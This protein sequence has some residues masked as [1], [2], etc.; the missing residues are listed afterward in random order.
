MTVSVEWDIGKYYE[1]DQISGGLT[2]KPGLDASIARLYMKIN[3]F[4]GHRKG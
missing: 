2:E 1:Q 4:G 3:I